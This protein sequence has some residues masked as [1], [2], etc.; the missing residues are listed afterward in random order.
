MT[1]RKSVK[2]NTRSNKN[3]IKPWSDIIGKIRIR[4]NTFDTRTVFSTSVGKKREDGTFANLYYDVYFKNGEVPITDAPEV[5]EIVVLSGF[6]TLRESKDGAIHPAIMVME[7]E[8][9]D[10]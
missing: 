7:W 3:E 1:K 6:L 9:I 5:F 4:S 10:Q 2:T 8:D